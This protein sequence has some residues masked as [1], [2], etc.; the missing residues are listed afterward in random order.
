VRPSL[1]FSLDTER[2]EV[3]S[4]RPGGFAECAG[5]RVGDVT[6]LFTALDIV[7]VRLTTS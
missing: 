5:I 2:A 6:R 1:G 4:V 3:T 7:V